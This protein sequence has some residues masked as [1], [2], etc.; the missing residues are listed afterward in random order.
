LDPKVRI[1]SQS[2][3]LAHRLRDLLPGG[4]TRSATF[5][6][7]YPIAMARGEGERVIDV[8]GNEYLDFW[9]NFTAL[10]H[11]H[12]HPDIVRALG[13]QLSF[14]TVFPSP[15]V[16]QAELAERIKERL[17]SVE[18]IRFTNSGSEAVMLAVRAARAFTG[19]DLLVKA[20]GGYHGCW[21]QVPMTQGQGIGGQR[22]TPSAVN[23]LLRVCTYNDGPSLRAVMEEVGEQVAAV[24]LEPVMVGGGVLAGDPTFFKT[25]RE[26]CDSYGALL[27][28][29]EVVTLRLDAHGYQSVLGVEPDL[30]TLGKLIGGG[31]PVGAAGG[32]ARIM[33]QFDPRRA[34]FVGHSGTFNGNPLTTVGGRVSLD[35][36]DDEAIARINAL[37]EALASRL[38]GSMADS[39]VEG[40]IT[41][42]GSLVQLHLQTGGQVRAYADTNM[43]SDL[44]RRIHRAS[45]EEGFLFASRGLMCTSTVMDDETI[46]QACEAFDRAL[47]RMES[48]AL[49][50]GRVGR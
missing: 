7:P 10:V 8:D 17:K 11:G 19:R 34:D 48:V 18:L 21:E 13:T 14:G 42:C 4:D 36:L 28:L 15:S 1:T 33:E 24:L 50:A 25:A 30:T 6:E 16:A 23:D 44:L 38:A 31:L 5:Y 41:N 35:L 39:G 3:A 46:D 12:C 47:A 45:I 9:N 43:G 37:G 20:D 22:G 49:A 26:L 27:I 32:R 29:D 40:T 2:E